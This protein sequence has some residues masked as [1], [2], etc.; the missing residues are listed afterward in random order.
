MTVFLY[1]LLGFVCGIDAVVLFVVTG[2][3]VNDKSRAE[4]KPPENSGTMRAKT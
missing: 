4:L 1:W 3:Y 2:L